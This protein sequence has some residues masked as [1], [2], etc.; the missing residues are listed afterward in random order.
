MHIHTC[1][2]TYVHTSGGILTTFWHNY[3]L[4]YKSCTLYLVNDRDLNDFGFS[5]NYYMLHDTDKKNQQKKPKQ[6]QVRTHSNPLPPHCQTPCSSRH[7]RRRWLKGWS[8][9][10]RL[11]W[12]PG[13]APS[14]GTL[15]AP[16]LE[17]R[18]EGSLVFRFHC[19]VGVKKKSVRITLL[20]L[21]SY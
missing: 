17:G 2:H 6:K 20:L 1:I 15:K 12:G 19:T 11:P 18:K 14:R 10:G 21:S 13:A 8:R 7:A 4:R 3:K 5:Y 16:R 9:P